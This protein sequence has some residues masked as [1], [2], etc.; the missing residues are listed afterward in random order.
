MVLLRTDDN[1]VNCFV[2]FAGTVDA[3]GYTRLAL[4]RVKARRNVDAD[5]SCSK[6][7]QQ[8][9]VEVPQVCGR[10]L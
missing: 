10:C 2:G 5:V 8:G 7:R 6:G 3:L 1:D 4:H 9:V